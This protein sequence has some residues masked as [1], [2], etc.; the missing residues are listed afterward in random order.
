MLIE[1]ECGCEWYRGFVPN[2]VSLEVRCDMS[3][4]PLDVYRV[5]VDGPELIQFLRTHPGAT[6]FPTD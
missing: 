3:R 6:P 5:A 1:I 2:L 4:V